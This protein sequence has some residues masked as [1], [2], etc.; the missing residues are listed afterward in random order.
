[1]HR[2]VLG[3][4]LLMGLTACDKQATASTGQDSQ[5]PA[6]AAGIAC[7]LLEYDEVTNRLGTTFD[8]AGGAKQGDT[9]TCA[10]RLKGQDNPYLTLAFTPSDIDSV[11]F[12]ESVK[13]AGAY[14]MPDLGV[15]AY[16]QTINASGDTPPSLKLV[17]LSNS[18]RL[19][20]LHYGF[21]PDTDAAA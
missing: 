4:V 6:S 3:V 21:E 7:Q 13:P 15:I 1:V 16:R 5:W 2:L 19:A 14:S 12:S 8:S 17:W 10:L 20:T 18:D 11:V 9:Y